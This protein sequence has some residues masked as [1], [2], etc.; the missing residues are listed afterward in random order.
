MT[1][2]TTLMLPV[3]TMLAPPVSLDQPAVVPQQ[4]RHPH[5][6]AVLYARPGVI[7]T[8]TMRVQR[9]PRLSA[10]HLSC[11]LHIGRAMDGHKGASR[12]S[13]GEIIDL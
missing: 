3:V 7:L 11:K 10:D 6:D 9:V 12:R 1:K 5:R 4:A 13:E 8:A 2:G